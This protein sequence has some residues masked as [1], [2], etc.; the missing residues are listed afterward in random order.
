MSVAVF[1]DG[2]AK[3]EVFDTGGYRL[4]GVSESASVPPLRGEETDEQR[5]HGKL[6]TD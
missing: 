6:P 4:G 2:S 1:R 5:T 3:A